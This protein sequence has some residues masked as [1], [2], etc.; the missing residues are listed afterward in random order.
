MKTWLGLEVSERTTIAVAAR[1]E[2]R[3]WFAVP[4]IPSKR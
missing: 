2:P 4:R 3:S 1:N